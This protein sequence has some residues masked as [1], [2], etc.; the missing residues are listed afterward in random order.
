MAIRKLAIA[1]SLTVLGLGFVSTANA[2]FTGDTVGVS[3]TAHT[4]GA[5]EHTVFTGQT[6]TGDG[7][8]LIGQS[9]PNGVGAPLTWSYSQ[10]GDTF[11]LIVQN[12]AN[13]VPTTVDPLDLHL[14][15]TGSFSI[16]GVNIISD[17]FGLTPANIS[18]TGNSIDISAAAGTLNILPPGG[19][20]AATFQ[21]VP[22][23]STF[24]MMSL[25]AS[26]LA[27]GYMVRRRKVQG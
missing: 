14:S 4:T 25:V 18:F 5:I 13:G 20:L 2:G 27:G 10:T 6:V 1:L 17:S 24:I 3:L 11:K 19:S 15:T 12:L 9:W 26:G 8:N 21:V 22:E 16:G 23:A 7:A